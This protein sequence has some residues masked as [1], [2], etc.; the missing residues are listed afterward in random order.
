[1]PSQQSHAILHCFLENQPEWVGRGE[2]EQASGISVALFF[3][4]ILGLAAVCVS[5]L[6]AAVPSASSGKVWEVHSGRLGEASQA[7]TQLSSWQWWLLKHS[8]HSFTI[9]LCS[10]LCPDYWAP[11]HG[12]CRSFEAGLF[13]TSKSENC[14]LSP[15]P[16]SCGKLQ[17]ASAAQIFARVPAPL[18]CLSS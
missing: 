10:A 6:A 8:Y 18:L 15:P 2:L 17:A 3:P 12:I 9:G 1:M 7:V 13:N 4:V 16:T 5:V 11:L 14:H